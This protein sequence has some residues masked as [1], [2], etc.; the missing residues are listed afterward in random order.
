MLTEIESECQKQFEPQISP[1]VLWVLI[2]IQTVCKCHH[3][4]AKPA[5]SVLRVKSFQQK[6]P[7]VYQCNTL[8]MLKK[9]EVFS[10][11]ARVSLVS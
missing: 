5:A 6:V 4:F 8:S 2:W 3:W 9:Q 11:K 7:H 1:L 10:E